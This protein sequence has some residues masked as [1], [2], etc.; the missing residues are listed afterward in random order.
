VNSPSF[1]PIFILELK[2]IFG[3]EG[4]QAARSADFAIARFSFLKKAILVHG[5]WYYVRLATLV[6]YFFYKNV[7]LIFPPT[8]SAFQ[9]AFSS[10]VF[11]IDIILNHESFPTGLRGFYLFQSLFNAFLMTLFN[12]VFASAP[13][14]AFAL[15]EQPFPAKVLLSNPEKYRMLSRNKLMSWKLFFIWM[16]RAVWHSL[17]IYAFPYFAIPGLP[18]ADWASYGVFIYALVILVVNLMVIFQT[19]IQRYPI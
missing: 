1:N 18:I 6:P 2:G 12:I 15:Q 10:Q 3:K 13:I 17:L 16:L 11:D 7:T 4:S 5:H 19:S 14:L 8:Y 9:T